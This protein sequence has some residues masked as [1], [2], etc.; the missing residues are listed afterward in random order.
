MHPKDIVRLM[1]NVQENCSSTDEL[2]TQEVFDKVL[3]AYSNASWNEM[4]EELILKYNSEDIKTIKAVFNN[5]KVPFNRKILNKRIEQL[6]LIDS[7]VDKLL[8]NI[9]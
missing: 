3:N 2:F 7:N 5:I 4:S 9:N 8:K 6:S 1:N